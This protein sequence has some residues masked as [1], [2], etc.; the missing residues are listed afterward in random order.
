MEPCNFRLSRGC[1]VPPVPA[2]CLG[3]RVQKGCHWM[4]TR[5]SAYTRRY[6]GYVGYRWLYRAICMSSSC[7]MV[8]RASGSAFEGSPLGPRSLKLF[9]DSTR[10]EGWERYDFMRFLVS[11]TYSLGLLSECF[12]HSALSSSYLRRRCAQVGATPL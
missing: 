8:L 1:G 5:P 6:I 2:S 9:G 4:N 7:E 11:A 3:L 12:C 10:E